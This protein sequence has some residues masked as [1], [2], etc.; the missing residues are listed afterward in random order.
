[1]AFPVSTRSTGFFVTSAVWNA[2][3][4]DNLTTL[5]AGG[6]AVTS[7]A[8]G[9][10]ITASS[11][12]QFSRV[13]DVATGSVLVSGGLGSPPA[14]SSA[15]TISGLVTAGGLLVTNASSGFTAIE[16]THANGG[17]LTWSRSSVAKGYVGVAESL[18][19]GH[20]VNN[21]EVQA[22]SSL[23]LEGGTD[24]RSARVYNSTSSQG[25]NVYIDS[26]GI[27][28]RSTA[29]SQVTVLD[30]DVT[31]TDVVNT[32][33]PTTAYTF[34]VPGNTLGSTRGLRLTGIYNV[35]NNS[36]GSR[37]LTLTI[38]FGGSTVVSGSV[39]F[40]NVGS[41]NRYFG[42]FTLDL[43]NQNSASAQRAGF[44]MT[45]SVGATDANG[46]FFDG[47][48]FVWAGG[49]RALTVNTTSSQSVTVSAAWDAADASVSFRLENTVLELV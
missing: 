28:Y 19:A 12:S 42:K 24:V 7:Q 49:H 20:G 13:A 16:S 41:A 17:Y 22:V 37:S 10:L 34:S 43:R 9:D 6:I 31:V 27:L 23:Y 2:D 21:F 3:L 44:A 33:T 46:A 14:Y 11:A 48:N 35:A 39:A 32:T 15:P 38:D 4:V 25:A 29:G 1:M 30:T 18:T 40:G 36:G 45:H 26:S 8:A 5:R 47:G